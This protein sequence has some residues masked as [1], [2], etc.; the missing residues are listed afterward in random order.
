[1]DVGVDVDEGVGAAVGD[2]GAG[3]AAW[4]AVGVGSGTVQ[5][6]TKRRHITSGTSRYRTVP[7]QVIMNP[8]PGN[9]KL[10]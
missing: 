10:H 2:I 8:S 7:M 9:N 4:V 6:A 5:A 1:M 3:V